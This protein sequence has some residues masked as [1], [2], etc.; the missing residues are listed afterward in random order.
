MLDR[1][2]VCLVRLQ[3]IAMSKTVTFTFYLSPL[4][5]DRTGITQFIF[6]LLARSVH[7]QSAEMW[8]Y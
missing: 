5:P 2:N 3:W 4:R 6:V 7:S 1:A 8:D